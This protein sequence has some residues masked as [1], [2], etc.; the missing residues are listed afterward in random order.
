MKGTLIVAE[1]RGKVPFAPWELFI[2]ILIF[3]QEQRADGSVVDKDGW[4]SM[5]A[6]WDNRTAT[7]SALIV[8]SVTS[9]SPLPAPA[10][11]P[12][13]SVTSAYPQKDLTGSEALV[14]TCVQLNLKRL[15][16]FSENV[17]VI[18]EFILSWLFWLKNGL[19]DM[20]Y[21]FSTNLINNRMQS[22]IRKYIFLN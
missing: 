9:L 15:S 1:G 21:K 19:V 3:K 8:R 16:F 2:F 17:K 12:C 22:K 6:S 14:V 13:K 5:A 10:H 11:G 18:N 20:Y 4:Q 7:K